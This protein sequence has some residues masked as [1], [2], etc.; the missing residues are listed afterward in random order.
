MK[1]KIDWKIVC[2]GI[3]CLSIVEIYA[4]TLGLNGTLRAAYFAIVAGVIGLTIPS[5]LSR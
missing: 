1:R 2:M 4:M 5:P 3:L